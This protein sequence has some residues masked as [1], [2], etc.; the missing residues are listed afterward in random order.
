MQSRIA[1]IVF[2]D[3]GEEG[4]RGDKLRFAGIGNANTMRD[5]RDVTF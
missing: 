2:G 4:N 1:F 3:L 5:L